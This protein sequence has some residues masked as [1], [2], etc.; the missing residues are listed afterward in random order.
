MSIL[1]ILL[2]HAPRS[3]IHPPLEDRCPRRST[4]SQEH[5]SWHTSMRPV[6]THVPCRVYLG[7]HAPCSTCPPLTHT[8][9]CNCEGRSDTTCNTPASS[10][11]R[12]SLL[13]AQ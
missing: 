9:P 11:R 10:D 4:T 7:P 6:P 5:P 13:A 3:H 8:R 1:S 12:L 2:N